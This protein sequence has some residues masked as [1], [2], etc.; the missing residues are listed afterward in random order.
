MEALQISQDTIVKKIEELP[1]LPTI[2]YELSRAIND[3]M[4]ST[5]Q[6]E[7]IM[8]NDVSM[9][10]KVLKLANSAY[11]AIPG[12]VTNLARAI[13]Y[14]GFDTINQLVLSSSIIEALEVKGPSAFDV[15]EFWK[16]SI[17]VA[18]ASETI[19]KRIHHPAPSDLFT[20]GLVHDMGKI[21]IL[22]TD[23]QYLTDLSRWAIEKNMTLDEAERELK[24]LRHTH[25]GM[26]LA[27][28]WLLP[29]Q[30]QAVIK[31]HHQKDPRQRGGLTDDQNKFVDIVLLANLLIHAL[32]FGNSGH[33]KIL[34]APQELMSRLTIDPQKDFKPLLKEI[35]VSLDRAQDFIKLIGGSKQ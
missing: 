14:I 13:A 17:G 7:A 6:I 9:T 3:P 24:T 16:H 23:A 10:T 18:I 20:C 27:E 32:K 26:L 29:K 2:V 25:V 8:S 12:G 35:K 31:Y 1:S 33:K 15:N 28:K 21:A 30:I 22:L 5:K 11:Y 19:A 4:S 34:G